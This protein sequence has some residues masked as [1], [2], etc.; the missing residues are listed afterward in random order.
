MTNGPFPAYVY[1]LCVLRY[2]TKGPL[3]D[4]AWDTLE[5]SSLLE[6]EAGKKKWDEGIQS[7]ERYK[8][9]NI[10]LALA[11]LTMKAWGARQAACPELVMPGWV[12][13]L[14][15]V[16]PEKTTR[17]GDGQ[18]GRAEGEKTAENSI[19][20]VEYA[21]FPSNPPGY[22]PSSSAFGAPAGSGGGM[23]GINM[24]AM[25]MGGGAPTGGFGEQMGMGSNAGLDMGYDSMAGWEGTAGDQ[26]SGNLTWDLWTDIM[27]E[28]TVGEEVQNGAGRNVG[29]SC[30][31][32]YVAGMWGQNPGF[33]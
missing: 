21:R 20:G 4:R 26:T 14:K 2:R 6:N 7:K 1:L 5:Q 25:E 11:N 15:A 17:G 8:R 23:S 33:Q 22:A 28:T 10:Y 12:R 24:G 29:F 31:D 27:R 32:A 3:V 30:G 16:L 18:G 9:S 19:T 13:D